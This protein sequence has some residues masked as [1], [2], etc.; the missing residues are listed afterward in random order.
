MYCTGPK[1]RECSRLRLAQRAHFST[2]FGRIVREIMFQSS[3]FEIGMTGC[4][5]V[6]KAKPSSSTPVQI[7]L[8]RRADQAGDRI[9]PT[10]AKWPPCT[11]RNKT[12][13]VSEAAPFG[14]R[15]EAGHE[16]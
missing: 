10:L 2:P 4:M 7:G 6:V 11:L 8:D 3:L 16:N 5:F 14:S 15:L 1:R 13:E 12:A 9:I